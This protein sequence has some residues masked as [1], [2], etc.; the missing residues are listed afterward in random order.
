MIDGHGDLP[1]KS[2]NDQDGVDRACTTESH[3]VGASVNDMLVTSRVDGL[4]QW[5]IDNEQLSKLESSSAAG[6]LILAGVH[7]FF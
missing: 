4:P 7:S 3:Y 1:L 6:L 2:G 5:I